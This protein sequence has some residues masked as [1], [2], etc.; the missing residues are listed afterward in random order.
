[1]NIRLRRREATRLMSCAQPLGD[2]WKADDTPCASELFLAT[3]QYNT[4]LYLS[5]ALEANRTLEAL[6]ETPDWLGDNTSESKAAAGERNA[7]HDLGNAAWYGAVREALSTPVTLC[8]KGNYRDPEAQRRA[9]ARYADLNATHVPDWG[10]RGAAASGR[11][12]VGEHK[13]YSPLVP[14][15]AGAGSQGGVAQ[16]GDRVAC[17]NT[18]EGLV[19]KVLGVAQ[20]G[21]PGERHFDHETGAGFVKEHKG[22]YDD[23]INA[24]G[25][26]VLLLISEVF[27]GVN[28]TSLR[29]LTRLAH[30]MKGVG[31][32]PHF[33]R[34]G[35]RVPY[36][37]FHAQAISRAAAVGH[38]GVLLKH[39]QGLSR[40]AAE[41]KARARPVVGAAAA[42]EPPPLP[43]G[44]EQYAGLA[45]GDPAAAAAAAAA[46][47]A[48]IRDARA[49]TA[50]GE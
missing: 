35:R 12:L 1:M 42:G 14:A 17:G 11:H 43:P 27:G 19:R 46:L 30:A 29:F 48:M 33:D 40:R 16:V 4:G 37:V 36:F 41:L 2:K 49:A 32:C 10:A 22:D 13:C 20:R 21:H 31:D 38:G 7:R 8:V 28:G 6:G 23:A 9:R 45:N 50:G 3:L 15:S 25:N 44:L 5:C 18:E 47:D 26:T 34:A 24:K 39:A